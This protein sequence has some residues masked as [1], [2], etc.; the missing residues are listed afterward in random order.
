MYDWEEWGPGDEYDFRRH[1]LEVDL[2]LHAV[3]KI[4]TLRRIQPSQAIQLDIAFLHILI[5]AVVT[6][7]IQDGLGLL[8]NL[9]NMRRVRFFLCGHRSQDA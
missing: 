4:Q 9:K 3:Q 7:A 5:V 8:G 6:V 2:L 1:V